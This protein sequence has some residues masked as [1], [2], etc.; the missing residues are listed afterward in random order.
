MANSY[1]LDENGYG[2][3][4]C[5]RRKFSISDLQSCLYCDRM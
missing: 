3:C 4:R 5:C 2:M 1:Q